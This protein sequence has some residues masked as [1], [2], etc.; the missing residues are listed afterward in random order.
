M[1]FLLI[2]MLILMSSTILSVVKYKGDLDL[3][4]FVLIFLTLPLCWQSVEQQLFS[5]GVYLCTQG[6]QDYGSMNPHDS[7]RG[8]WRVKYFLSPNISSCMMWWNQNKMM[9]SRC[10][11]MLRKCHKVI[12]APGPRAATLLWLL[13]EMT[14]Q[15][16]R[17]LK[18]WPKFLSTSA[19]PWIIS[20]S[21][22]QSK[23]QC[24]VIS[25][26]SLIKIYET[27]IKYRRY[28]M[29]N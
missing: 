10:L 20:S 14:R 18:R 22:H 6:S 24:E 28:C 2:L 3:M 7:E 11:L 29:I 5:V 8:F 27:I 23:L 16:W 21:S 25:Q 15:R 13:M 17:M 26:S 1:H 12:P 4:K 19:R 9:L